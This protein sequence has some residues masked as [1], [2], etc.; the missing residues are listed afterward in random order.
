MWYTFLITLHIICGFNI[1]D[2]ENLLLY[3]HLET[4]KPNPLPNNVNCGFRVRQLL[5]LSYEVVLFFEHTVS[6]DSS[7][8]LPEV[9]CC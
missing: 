7:F 5:F 4:L 3:P 6:G 9:L 1:L 2:F 8:T